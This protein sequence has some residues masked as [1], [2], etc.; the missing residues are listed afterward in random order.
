MHRVQQFEGKLSPDHRR[1]L[2]DIF[3]WSQPIEPGHQQVVQ[4]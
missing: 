1:N 3:R 4:C 2:C